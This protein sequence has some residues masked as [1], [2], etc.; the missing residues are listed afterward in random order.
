MQT[1]LLY[2]R[3]VPSTSLSMKMTTERERAEMSAKDAEIAR[4][5]EILV[6]AAC[7][8]IQAEKVASA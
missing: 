8:N 5:K 2:F 6:A 3:L 7:K 4:L 1:C